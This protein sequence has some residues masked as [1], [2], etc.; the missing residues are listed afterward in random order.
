MI[1]FNSTQLRATVS[2]PR[3]FSLLAS[4]ELGSYISSN[5]NHVVNYL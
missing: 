5:S 3:D 1:I 4:G 2:I